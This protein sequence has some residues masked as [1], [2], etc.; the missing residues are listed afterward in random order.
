MVIVTKTTAPKLDPTKTRQVQEMKHNRPL[1]GCRFDPSGRFVF[2]GSEDNT[3]QRWELSNG[4]K[5]ALVGH[6]SWARG[7]AFFPAARLLVSGDYHGRL[8]W[9]PIDDPAPKPVRNLEAHDGWVRALAVSPDGQLLATCGNDHLVKLWSTTDAKPL[10]TLHGHTSHVYH[11]AFH[12]DGRQLAS[13]DQRGVVRH[14]DVADGRSV[15][16]LDAAALHKYD[17]SFRADIGGIRGMAFSRDGSLL[18][19]AG[20]TDVTNA[21]AGVGK[22]VVVLF[23]WASGKRKHLLRPKEEFQGTAWGVT[24]HPSGFLI[25]AGGG[26]GGALWFW[27]PDAAT[28][29]HGLKLPQNCR[30]LDLHADGFRLAVPQ[31]DGALR[32]FTMRGK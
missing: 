2:A 23:D 10:R 13:A 5:V 32:V 17:T 8:L 16:A 9:W 26:N 20:I 1:V 6:Q 14:W 31:A 7:L 15:R 18:A 19:C 12:P 29:F 27:K 22:P 3:I 24:F 4:Q 28:A 25:G 11:V 30:D 21:F